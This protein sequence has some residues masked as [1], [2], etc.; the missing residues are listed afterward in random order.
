MGDGICKSAHKVFRIK[1]H[2]VFCIKYRKDL[3][4]QNKYVETFKK[5]CREFENRDHM[6]FETI[7]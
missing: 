3:F 5:V 1:Y 2:F 4:L 7:G 6:K